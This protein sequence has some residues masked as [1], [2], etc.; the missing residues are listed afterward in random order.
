MKRKAKIYLLIAG[1]GI[2]IILIFTVIAH[3]ALSNSTKYLRSLNK[4]DLEKEKLIQE[5]GNVRSIWNVL[6]NY[7]PFITALVALLGLFVTIWKQIEQK[8]YEIQIRKEEKFESIAA[9]L[10]S[11]NQITCV[12]AA[13]SILTFLK[14]EYKEFHDQVYMILV[15][16]LKIK[17]IIDNVVIH[18]ILLKAF[19]K[20]IRIK[21]KNIDKSADPLDLSRTN[22]S[23]TGLNELP[24][25]GVDLGFS[26]LKNSN[27]CGS[28]MRRARGIKANLEKARLT[29][30]N[31]NEARFQKANFYRTNLRNANLVAADLQYA[32]LKN[33]QL[34][35]AKMQSVLFKGA[36]LHGARFEG[37]NIADTHFEG[38]HLDE[39]TIE[40]LLNANWIEAHF[41]PD[42]K[43]ILEEKDKKKKIKSTRKVNA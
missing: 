18:R 19:E 20:A 38:S 43:T 24:L 9:K 1:I 25:C 21:L 10:S 28:N 2:I 16:N 26:I 27:F 30:A 32:N 42:I 36:R 6:S 22:L 15:G 34:Q 33:T 11:D 12:I 29:G 7:A 8:R 40:S 13:A 41:D 37:A 31:L 5:I 39:Q 4:D 23:G 3:Y 35:N 14:D 17:P